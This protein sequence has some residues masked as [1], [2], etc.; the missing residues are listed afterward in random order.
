MA[1][2]KTVW[3]LHHLSSPWHAKVAEYGRHRGK[4]Q[5]CAGCTLHEKEREEIRVNEAVRV[6]DLDV[7][8]KMGISEKNECDG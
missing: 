7:E 6:M 2:G 3:G 8:P 5:A 1:D 4:E